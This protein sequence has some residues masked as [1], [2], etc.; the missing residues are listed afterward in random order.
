MKAKKFIMSYS[1]GKDSTL[2]LHKWIAAGGEPVGLLTMVNQDSERSFFHG[3][4]LPLLEKYGR[5]LALP[6]LP[7]LSSGENYHLAMEEALRKARSLGAEQVCFGDIDLEGNR[8]WGEERC[9]H[10]GLEAVYPLWQRDRVENVR[11]LL[12]LGYRCLIKSINNRL[13]PKTLL[14]RILDEAALAEME[15]C[16]IDVCGENGEYHTLVVDGPVFRQPL[17]YTTGKI[18]DFGDFSVIEVE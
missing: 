17:P 5:A 18:L 11:E 8:K 15:A 9:A 1:C 6:L 4:D 12:S 7:V 3:A 2:A 13:L 10:A 14:G 16:G